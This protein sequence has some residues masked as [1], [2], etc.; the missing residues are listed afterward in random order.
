MFF[1]VGCTV[2]GP[3]PVGDMAP[4]PW[5]QTEKGNQPLDNST[6]QVPSV[7]FFL[8]GMLFLLLNIRSLLVFNF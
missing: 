6:K 2:H 1:A 8:G 5:L 7:W 3:L 4:Y